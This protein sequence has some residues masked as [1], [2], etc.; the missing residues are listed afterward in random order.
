VIHLP[1]NNT[2]DSDHTGILQSVTRT[3]SEFCTPKWHILLYSNVRSNWI[4]TKRLS[5][6]WVHNHCVDKGGCH[7]H[8]LYNHS[9]D[10]RSNFDQLFSAVWPLTTLIFRASTIDHVAFQ[11]LTVDYMHIYGNIQKN[12]YRLHPFLSIRGQ[13]A[14]LQ[15]WLLGLWERHPPWV[16]EPSTNIGQQ[17]LN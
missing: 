9:C 3:F 15:L 8:R 2:A 1:E 13:D 14:W 12:V 11:P 10:H 17:V 6:D 16:T 7:S 5:R 4:V